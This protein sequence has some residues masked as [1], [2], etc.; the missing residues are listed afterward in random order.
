[1]SRIALMPEELANQIAAGEVVERPASVVKELVENSLD[2]GAQRIDVDI[3]GGGL[4]L[5][6]V[7][8]DGGGMSPEDAELCLLRHAT[9]KLR[10][11]DDLF[12]LETM[13]FRGE[14][15]AS[16]ASVS[17]LTL[18]TRTPDAVA[19]YRIILEAGQ[20]T[21]P[22]R[23]VGGQV[24]TQ[25]EVR[26]LFY[27]VPARLKFMKS[28]ATESGHVTETLLRLSLAFPGV[29]FR[30]RQKGKVT[31][32]LPPH[33]TALERSRAALSARGK[34]TGAPTLHASRQ[35]ADGME[36]EVHIGPPDD[37][38][39]TP[40]NVFLLCN[41]RFVRDRLLLHAAT[42][43]YGEL[44][45]RGRYPLLVVN[46]ELNP[47]TVDV[48]VHPQKLE[49]RMAQSDA[50][51]SLVRQAVRNVCAAAPWLRSAARI[52]TLGVE[53][54]TALAVA[55]G[56]AASASVGVAAE[57][58]PAYGSAPS[59]AESD[60]GADS[61]ARPEKRPSVEHQ[62]P[63]S[64]FAPSGGLAEHRARMRQALGLYA[65]VPE[66]ERPEPSAPAAALEPAREVTE[67]RESMP[68]VAERP[69]PA[70]EAAPD[71]A[72]REEASTSEPAATEE[73]RAASSGRLLFAQSGYL[74]QLL[75]TY[76]LC[77]QGDELL[78]I[79]QHA[80]HE[81]VVFERLRRA[82]QMGGAAVKSQRLLF[83]VSLELDARRAA[84]VEEH[85]LEL[86][87]LGFEVRPFGGRS[88]ALLAAPDLAAYGRSALGDGQRDPEQLFGHVLDEL[89]EHGRS[90]ALHAQVDLLLAT[91]ACHAA[92]RAG[93]PLD[94]QKA[95]ALLE[96][97]DEVDYSPHC[98]HGRP[99]LVRMSRQEI[100]KRFGRI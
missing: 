5:V 83:P 63:L 45:E 72:P 62:L 50:V 28:E 33:K 16:I 6:R 10:S 42:S 37:S 26:D 52:Y 47:A 48:N 40:R 31:L 27:N 20:K 23:E 70:P 75:G 95:R 30:L 93:D 85:A 43:G 65:P 58:R 99:V 9:S 64:A 15:L 56:A 12:R 18:T 80:A 97:M 3:E 22:S 39:T 81:R 71:A 13:G 35:S 34:G 51:Y 98:P 89:D 73:A 100:E 84:L 49:V 7:T 74:G 87:R 19:A 46:L 17:R 8:D 86:S 25:F 82:R 14:A 11:A 96:A 59:R 4:S 55:G 76:L 92:V 57:P 94:E 54:G 78:L 91:M 29:H 69:A 90:D 79:D 67:A 53:Q 24:G 68:A 44:L 32:D 66:G 41:R 88:F 21:S 36:V 61:R 77:E 1:M 2:A 38:T 60:A